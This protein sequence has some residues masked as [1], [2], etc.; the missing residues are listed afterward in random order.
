M[1][2]QVLSDDRQDDLPDLCLRYALPLVH[3]A[4]V[5]SS[6]GVSWSPHIV[7]RQGGRLM[8]MLPF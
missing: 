4:R 8:G 1:S 7:K 2:M 5:F 6:G 3:V